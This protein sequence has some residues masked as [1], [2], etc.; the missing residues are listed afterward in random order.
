MRRVDVPTFSCGVDRTKV[1]AVAQSE[2]LE[3][4]TD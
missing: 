1:M 2:K 3:V 4:H